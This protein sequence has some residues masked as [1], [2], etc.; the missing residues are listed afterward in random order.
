MPLETRA[1]PP[2]VR[3]HTNTSLITHTNTRLIT[4]TNTRLSFVFMLYTHE[5]TAQESRND[6]TFQLLWQ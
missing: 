6:M 4:H 2:G 1:S 3:I 5:Y